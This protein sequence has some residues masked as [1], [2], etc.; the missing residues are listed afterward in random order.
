MLQ[1]E[2]THIKRK[3]YLLMMLYYIALALNWYNPLCWLI[4]FGVNKDIEMACDEQTLQ[5]YINGGKKILCQNI[6]SVM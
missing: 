3:D 4:Y 1:H 6:T 2:K 5:K